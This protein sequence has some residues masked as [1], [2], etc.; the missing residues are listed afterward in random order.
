MFES[1]YFIFPLIV[2]SIIE[3]GFGNP[4]LISKPSKYVTKMSSYC[5]ENNGSG[6][7]QKVCAIG[8]ISNRERLGLLTFDCGVFIL[9][10]FVPCIPSV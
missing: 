2:W 9:G 6:F 1:S 8:Y 5:V 3:C 4:V 7:Q 10:Y